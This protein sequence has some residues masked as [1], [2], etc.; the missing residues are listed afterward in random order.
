[1]TITYTPDMMGVVTHI[2]EI[3]LFKPFIPPR[4]VLM[5]RLEEVL[6]SG[7]IAEGEIVRKFEQGFADYIRKFEQ[8]FADYIEFPSVVATSSCT[9]ALHMALILSGVGP[10]DE[11]ISTPMTAIPTNMAILHTGAKIVWADVRSNGN[12]DWDIVLH[13]TTSKTKAIMAVD[14]AGIP[15]H[16]FD[17]W[18]IPPDIPIIDDSAHAL[19]ARWDGHYLAGYCDFV[20]HSFQAIKHL[21]TVDGGALAINNAFYDERARKL[22]WFGIDKD[23]PRTGQN[24]SSVGYKYNMNNVTAAIGLV[25]LDY[26]EGNLRRHVGN[27]QYFDRVLSE[28][29]GISV[30]QFDEFAEP[31]YWLYT[32]LAETESD[33]DDLSA[34]LTEAGIGNGLVHRRNDLHDVFAESKCYLPGLDWFYSHMLHIPCGWWVT[35]EDR[36]YIAEVIKC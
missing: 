33:R 26:I 22:R 30:A 23:A 10:G 3:P 14:Y 24:I 8:E 25:Q 27:G 13:K 15:M 2:R 16:S 9:A 11:V 31:S 18:D 7:Y 21:T 29:P 28:I 12:I 34:K 36:E 5:P 6:Y 35:D 4:D 17:M 1:M 20:T 19:G 32:V